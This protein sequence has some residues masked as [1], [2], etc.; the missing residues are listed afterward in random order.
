M[1]TTT[2]NNTAAAPPLP[3][4]PLGNTGLHISVLGFG[5]SAL[6]G[7]FDDFAGEDEGIAAVLE[8]HSLGVN[9]F[10]TS[11]FY[12]ATRSERVLGRALAALQSSGASRDSFVVSTKVGRYGQDEFDFSAA[13]VRKSVD[14]SLERLGL[15][16]VDLL[17]A[18]DVEFGDL[19]L[20]IRETLPEMQRLK[21][22]GK[23]SFIGVTGLPLGALARIVRECEPGSV[24]VVLSYCHHCL[25]DTSL[26]EQLLPG[27]AKRGVGVINASPLSMGLLSRRGPPTW[28]PAPQELKEACARA[29]ERAEEL[30]EDVSA[31]AV[32][33][34]VAQGGGGGGE[35]GGGAIIASNLVSMATRELVRAN[36]SA[37]LEALDVDAGAGCLD[38]DEAVKEKKKEK[39]AKALAEVEAILAPVKGVTWPSG[40]PEN[41]DLST[42]L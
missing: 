22:E 26:Q 3:R 19:G 14:E 1:A 13:R 41:N 5:A 30:G 39:A 42:E 16:R 17:L 12:G 6:G 34:S 20:V 25:C 7:V 9:Y 4:R 32:A 28:H 40:R 10:D 21:R 36:V 18:H 35:E 11:P 29:A 23:C 33:F 15:D 2:D 37:A 24:D 31:M 8:A 38:D 27:L